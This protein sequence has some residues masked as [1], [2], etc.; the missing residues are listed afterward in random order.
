MPAQ[1][2]LDLSRALVSLP[3]DGH[4]ARWVELP[5]AVRTMQGF[6]SLLRSRQW[7]NRLFQGRLQFLRAGGLVEDT[8]CLMGDIVEVVAVS[9]EQRAAGVA[10]GA[11]QRPEAAGRNTGSSVESKGA[12]E[13]AAAAAAA[14]LDHSAAAAVEAAAAAATEIPADGREGEAVSAGGVGGCWGQQPVVKL[15]RPERLRAVEEMSLE[16]RARVRAAGIPA[17]AIEGGKVLPAL[18]RLGG[19]GPPMEVGKVRRCDHCDVLKQEGSFHPFMWVQR[20]PC[21]CAQCESELKCSTC[22]AGNCM[23]RPKAFSKTQAR[24]W[25]GNRRCKACVRAALAA[26]ELET[27]VRRKSMSIQLKFE[28]L[29]WRLSMWGRATPVRMAAL[30]RASGGSYIRMVLLIHSWRRH[31][32]EAADEAEMQEADAEFGPPGAGVTSVLPGPTQEEIWAAEAEAEVE[33]ERKE[34]E[35]ISSGG[36]VTG[37]ELEVCGGSDCT[38]GVAARCVT[39]NREPCVLAAGSSVVLQ[40]DWGPR[41]GGDVLVAGRSGGRGWVTTQDGTQ[42]PGVWAV[43]ASEVRQ[44]DVGYT[45]AAEPGAEEG[46]RDLQVEAF[47]WPDEVRV[48]GSPS[49]EGD[50]QTGSIGYIEVGRRLRVIAMERGA[51]YSEDLCSRDDMILVGDVTPQQFDVDCTEAGLGGESG[52]V[53]VDY[54]MELSFDRERSVGHLSDSHS[55]GPPGWED[56]EGTTR[57]GQGCVV[58]MELAEGDIARVKRSS[59][60]IRRSSWGLS[61]L[62]EWTPKAKEVV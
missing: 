26:Q 56:P 1:V 32:V 47:H 11:T 55:G 59:V 25:S 46:D 13:A 6:E 3:E 37:E 18:Q 29:R 53:L 5:A 7:G 17:E 24:N 52:R 54:S 49:W 4:M 51:R 58:E 36:V 14:S 40:R 8:G 61:T 16:E 15:S 10:T 12:A 33:Q 35:F 60:W 39:S 20:Y 31:T 62:R 45:W 28:K 23:K 22:P 27:Q 2:H 57:E 19:R 34:Q 9:G 43:S 30:A 21:I 41:A 44:P 48:A 38:L 42:L 50:L